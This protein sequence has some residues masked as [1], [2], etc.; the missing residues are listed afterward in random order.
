MRVA[1]VLSN[2][3]G[4]P[5]SVAM[6]EHSVETLLWGSL[7]REAGVAQA[8]PHCLWAMASERDYPDNCSWISCQ[9]KE[10]SHSE[11]KSG[12]KLKCT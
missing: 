5:S 11:S 1:M 8:E 7:D 4:V 2:K 6:P 9:E 12:S 3:P 10:F